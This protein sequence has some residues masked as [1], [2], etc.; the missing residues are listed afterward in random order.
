MKS[1][2]IG[3]FGRC[4]AELLVPKHKWFLHKWVSFSAQPLVLMLSTGHF[5]LGRAFLVAQPHGFV[6]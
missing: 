1:L 5:L 6:L 4:S 3:I 2:F